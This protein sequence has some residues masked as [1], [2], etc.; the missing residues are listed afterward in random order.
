MDLSETDREGTRGVIR[1]RVPE[2]VIGAGR[3]ESLIGNGI[4]GEKL[5]KKW[6]INFVN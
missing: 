3:T 6:Q 5:D 4:P 2:H 1:A